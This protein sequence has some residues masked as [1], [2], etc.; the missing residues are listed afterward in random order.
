MQTVKCKNCKCGI[1]KVQRDSHN[2]CCGACHETKDITRNIIMAIKQ[3]FRK[4]R[5]RGI[6]EDEDETASNKK[7]K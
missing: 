5:I 4:M 6:K 3:K 1:S 2:G 7:E